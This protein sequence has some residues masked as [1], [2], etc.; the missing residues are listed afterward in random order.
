M[1]HVYERGTHTTVIDEAKDVIKLLKKA[2]VRISPGVI[3]GSDGTRGKSVK[4]K[5][6]NNETFEMVVVI[7]SAKQIFKVYG[8]NQEHVFQPLLE[9]RKSGWIVSEVMDI[10]MASK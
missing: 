9:L 7:K 1:T 5:K 3:L 10:S 6:L 2:K 8:R 4:L